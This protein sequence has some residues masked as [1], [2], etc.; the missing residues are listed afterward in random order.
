MY[1]PRFP[2]GPVEEAAS[3]DRQAYAFVEIH[4]TDPVNTV[5]LVGVSLGDGLRFDFGKGPHLSIPP[6][7]YMVVVE[8]PTAFAARYPAVT[9]DKIAGEYRG[10][11]TFSGDAIDLLVEGV[12]PVVSMEYSD[13][14]GWPLAAD[15]AGHSLI[16]LVLADQSSGRLDYGGNWKASVHVD[17]SPGAPEPAPLDTVVLNEII[18]HTD[19]S[20]TNFPGYDSNDKIELINQSA[21]TVSLDG[22]YSMRGSQ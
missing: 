8:N 16:P 17:G 12:G 1:V 3:E 14:R 7:G 19:F 22:T 20:D 5:G 10:D 9:A 18:A 2:E 21:S 6:G 15:G 13:G 4:N 11:L